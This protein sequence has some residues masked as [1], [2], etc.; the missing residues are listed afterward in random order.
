MNKLSVVLCVYGQDDQAYFKEAFE[1]ILG[2]TYQPE[3]LVIVIDGP[4]PN[5]FKELI[6]DL[7]AQARSYSIKVNP[8]WLEKNLGH[9]LARKNGILNCTYNYVAI[10]DADDINCK[11]RFDKQVNFLKLNQQIS[12]VGSQILEIDH[13]TKKALSLKKVPCSQE[14][15]A[16]YLKTRCPLNQ[17]SVMFRKDDVLNSGGYV[18]F[19]HNEDYY[20]WIRM[21]ILGY[22]FANMTDV[23]VHARVNKQ[24][25]DRRGGLKYFLSEAK[26]QKYMLK[27]GVISL[28]LYTLNIGIRFLVQIVIP[29]RIRGKIFQLLFRRKL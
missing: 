14:A 9:G 12:V 21:H 22:K 19:F 8:I 6:F 11:D 28:G 25:Y 7:I 2:Q 17:M 5:L 13:L 10:A 1:S 16:V 20:L 24:F 3:E 4:I 27:N 26:L 23:L 29:P 15:L 18:N